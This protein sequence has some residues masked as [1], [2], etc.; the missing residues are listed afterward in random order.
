MNFETAARR[1]ELARER[2]GADV[3]AAQA[4]YEQAWAEAER[5]DQAGAFVTLSGPGQVLDEKRTVAI[6]EAGTVLARLEAERPAA[7][8][9]G[10]G[11][12]TEVRS[13]GRMLRVGVRHELD[14]PVRALAA[15]GDGARVSAGQTAATWFTPQRWAWENYREA[16]TYVL[17]F[18]AN[19]VVVATVSMVLGLFFASLS[20][21]VLV[22]FNFPGKTLFYGMLV[23]LLMIPGVLNLIPMYIIV[24]NM[25]LLNSLWAV[26][27]PAVAGAQVM[28][29][30]I[31]RNNLETVAKDLFDAAR[32]D[33]ASNWQ[34]Y[35][36][37]AMPLSKPIMGTL[38]IFAL[39][40]EWNN[41][42]WP[43]IVLKDMDKMTI[44]AGLALLEGQ[45][46]SDY[47]LQMAGSV[48][49]SLPLVIMF[50]FMMNLFIRGIQSGAVKA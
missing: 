41:F 45:N 47:G 30:Y 39:L 7:G 25:G 43:W 28:N 29:V 46:Q 15:A 50:L 42:I 44:T 26:I 6:V 40:S 48:L 19:T 5:V 37:I 35:W 9:T 24:K 20:A 14:L 4:A 3:T 36:H 21:F 13:D 16:A 1:L 32:I 12:V 22:R 33:G 11:A 17:P 10:G 18:I 23:V 31:L 49:A 38:A 2:G 34:V 27:L 8:E